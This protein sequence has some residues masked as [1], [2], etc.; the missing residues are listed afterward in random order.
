MS[1]HQQALLDDAVKNVVEGYNKGLNWPE[2]WEN[3]GPPGGPWARD[4]RG[5]L[6]SDLWRFG[7]RAGHQDKLNK[8]KRGAS[9]LAQQMA[10][11]YATEFEFFLQRRMKEDCPGCG[12][13]HTFEVWQGS[14]R[15]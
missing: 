8:R 7:W 10:Y 6:L 14:T 3:H 5:E 4:A 13:E 15:S 1:P 11:H 9:V 2:E 12:H